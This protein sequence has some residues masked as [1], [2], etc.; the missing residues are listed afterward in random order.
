MMKT[1]N[2]SRGLNRLFV[3]GAF[4]WAI[5]CGCLFYDVSRGAPAEVAFL[6]N[7][8][9]LNAIRHEFVGSAGVRIYEESSGGYIEL[10]RDQV[11]KFEPG[12][13]QAQWWKNTGREPLALFFVPLVLTYAF[14]CG[15]YWALRGFRP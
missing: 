7:G 13:W 8:A 11:L 15:L 6:A 14:G 4:L 1:L 12:W 10:Q 3:I 2:L 9:K 5:V